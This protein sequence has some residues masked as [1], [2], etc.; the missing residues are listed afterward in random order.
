MI[1]VNPLLQSSLATQ[2]KI[3][4]GR[5]SK[6]SEKLSSGYRI[7]RAADDAASLT[8]SEKLRSQIRGLAQA[9][10]NIQDGISYSQVA[11]GAMNEAHDILQRMVGLSVDAANGTNTFEDRKA[12]DKEFHQLE[13]ELDR[14]F[15]STD[16]NDTSVFEEHEDTYGSVYGAVHWN[17]W[18]LHEVTSNPTGSNE[19]VID[20]DTSHVPAFDPNQVTVTVPEGVY[21]TKELLDEIDDRLCE[22][23][24]KPE[25][26]LK[27][28]MKPD[29]CCNVSLEG[30]Q[31]LHSVSGGLS[32][33]LYGG[34]GGGGGGRIIGTTNLQPSYPLVI[35]AG[36]ND[37]MYFRTYNMEDKTYG[38][39]INITFPPGRY[40]QSDAIDY[41]NDQ[42]KLQ[43]PD[44]T[45]EAVAEGTNCVSLSGG[46]QMI[47]GLGGNMFEIDAGS[48]KY[49]SIFYDYRETGDV[50]DTSATFTGAAYYNSLTEKIAITA[51]VNDKLSISVDGDA[52]TELTIAAGDYTMDGLQNALKD[53]LN[54]AGLG[55]RIN[56]SQA[57]SYRSLNGEYSMYQSL[58]LTSTAKGSDSSIRFRTQNDDGTENSTYKKSYDA[59]F[60]NTLI[61]NRADYSSGSQR[62][63]SLTGRANL[64]GGF[65]FDG[66]NNS[67]TLQIDTGTGATGY[68]VSFDSRAYS[69][70]EIVQKFQDTLDANAA[71]KN[72]DG[73]SKVKVS[74]S[75]GGLHFASNPSDA[76]TSIGVNHAS[77]GFSSLF[78]STVTTPNSES[79]A[80]SGTN[81]YIEGDTKPVSQ[82]PAKIIL[83]N[84]SLSSI[85]ITDANRDFTI[86]VGG[87]D[88]TVHL[89]KGTYT[90]SSIVQQLNYQFDYS[91]PPVRVTA[92][93]YGNRLAFTTDDAGDG[94]S[95][96]ITSSGNPALGAIIG[97]R[98]TTN[99]ELSVNALKT[100]AKIDGISLDGRMPDNSV[101][102][103]DG[104]GPDDP[105]AN[106]DFHFTYQGTAFNYSL[107]AGTYTYDSLRT[108][109]QNQIDTTFGANKLEVTVGK[110]GGVDIV[111]KEVG[112]S[113]S[114]NG[115]GGGFYKYVVSNT[116][117]VVSRS[118][119]Q[120]GTHRV[121]NGY[122]VGRN[123]MTD[124]KDIIAGTNDSLS[125]KFTLPVGGTP[126]TY[127]LSFTLP[128]GTYSGAQLIPLIQNGLDAQLQAKGLPKGLIQA[129]IG[130][131]NTGV[132]GNIDNKALAFKFVEPTGY[133]AEEGSYIIDSI[134]GSAAY[135]VFYKSSGVP[136]AAYMEG[137]EYIGG[138]VTIPADRNQF[139]ISV[140]GT[141]Y[142][143]NLTPGDYTPEDLLKEL[144][145]QF[146]AVPLDIKSALTPDGRLRIYY[147][148]I[149]SHT[150][151]D[152][153]GGSKGII[154]YHEESRKDNL[155]VV[156]QA[157]TRGKGTLD[158]LKKDKPNLSS[159]LLGVNTCT[160]TAPK[161]ARKAMERVKKAIEMLSD[162]RSS[163]GAFQN[164]LQSAYAS[165]ENTRENTTAADSLLRDTNMAKE[166]VGYSRDKVLQQV[167][168]N[169]QSQLH[170][171]H[172]DLVTNLL[173]F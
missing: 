122:I 173:R 108:Q 131:V 90:P 141:D 46:Y 138:G 28:E 55:S 75:G 77:S 68:T 25:A 155:E 161:Y 41:I 4:T 86:R 63:A 24:I 163:F 120:D 82:D 114:L 92:G 14:I 37:N 5:Y 89:D 132:Y 143:V 172:T 113:C 6:T 85:V 137:S 110:T 22:V 58:Y 50:S 71:L 27:I 1:I 146:A 30:Q 2:N 52:Y 3:T 133:T 54:A 98:S 11:D 157:G 97:T 17:P 80:A 39:E 111:S 134:S 72:T 126:K 45:A 18:E 91:E 21:T 29:G 169:L 57:S 79:Q 64:S 101:T 34:S 152:I 13:Q 7:N 56:V 166:T 53:A 26:Q 150:L 48:V 33:L 106:D 19:L 61:T 15:K 160:L 165:N 8:I 74:L 103:Y 88:R 83:N 65:T 171:T 116:A 9:D 100:P 151:S 38:P 107:P 43:D 129:G 159:S 115:V 67:V 125:L 119:S 47:V 170:R 96:S 109:L 168:Q 118:T 164:R 128:E 147:N 51:G 123:D 105:Y 135:S 42:I 35:K 40:S 158:Q 142:T 117:T 16:F 93:L 130:T 121:T 20:L 84:S 167:Q 144:D 136:H 139:G 99:Y 104:S 81:H 10:R 95:V 112:S 66:S 12:M 62:S 44:S 49:N 87:V 59:L 154:F 156:V 149:G 69:A 140:D 73:S 60:S 23:S 145:D 78:T 102:I 36:M 162:E 148:E 124:V 127:E 94:A 76:L 153:S 31:G 70:A 32:R